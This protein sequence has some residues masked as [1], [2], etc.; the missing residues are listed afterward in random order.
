MYLYKGGNIHDNS[1]SSY[2]YRLC[3]CSWYLWA[4]L[5][6]Q[7]VKNL[8]PMRETWVQSL[9]WE[10]PL[11]ESVAMHSS[12]LTWRIP[13]D[14]GTWRAT[15][16]GVVESDTTEWLSTHRADICNYIL[17][18]ILYSLCPQQTLQLVTILYLVGWPKPSF[19]KGLVLDLE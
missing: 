12:I 6:A 4:S 19:V 2:H 16:D 3:G 1:S 5:V 8:P 17:L 10:D 7:M 14:R 11:E 13:M 9:S 15:G 18:S